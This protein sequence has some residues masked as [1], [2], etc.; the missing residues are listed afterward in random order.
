MICFDSEKKIL[1][2]L[3]RNTAYQMQIGPLGYLLHLYYG[4]RM[5]TPA[6]Y[7]YLSSDCGFSPNPY[8]LRMERTWSMDILPQEYSGSDSGDFRLSALHLNT[9]SGMHGADFRY[10]R[11]EISSGKYAL[12]GLPSASGN[13]SDV[14]TLTVTLA[15]AATGLTAQLFYGVY[16][17]ADIITRA[18]RLTNGGRENLFLEK[19]ASMC[20]DIPFGE[21][22]MMSFHGRH[23]MER[24]PERVPLTHDIRT[25]SSRRGMSSHQRNPFVILCARDATED[26]G[27]CYGMMPMYSGNHKTEIECDQMDSV[28]VVSGIHDEQFRWRLAPGETFDTPEILLGFSHEGLTGL[29]RMYHS[30]LRRH[31]CRAVSAPRPV[32]IN[33]WEAT[34]FN[35]DTEKILRIGR[36]ARELGADMLVLDDGWFGRRNDDNSGL[37]DWYVNESKLP[38]GLNVLIERL[39]ETGLKFGLWVEPEMVSEDSDLY[40]AHPDW[41][42]TVPG[43][44]PAMGRN[45]LVLDLSRKEVTG[46]MYETLSSLLKSHD[47]SYIKWDMNRCLADVYSHALPSERQGEVFHRYVLGLYSVLERLTRAFPHVLVEGCAGGGGRFD[48]GM[49]TYCPQIWCSDDTDAVE[50]LA[51]QHGTSFG[52][53]PCTM[54][55]HVSAVPNHQTGRCVPL[56]TRAVVAMAGTFGYELDLNRLSDD[57][58][59]QVREQIQRFH[60]Y[61]VLM[62]EGDYY[63]LAQS[64]ENQRFTAWQFVSPDRSESLVSL[65]V[66]HPRANPQPLHVR[67]KGLNPDADYKVVRREFFGSAVPADRL[68]ANSTGT[69]ERHY[70]GASLMYAGYT[71]P[72]MFG[73]YPSAQIYLKCVEKS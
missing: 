38:G 32:L 34:Y 27:E 44:R 49:L 26:S 39:K 8:E 25:V 4:R 46:W 16:E 71:F 61:D 30:F 72:G 60:E 45:Q 65:V 73:D 29:S 43:R 58:K 3:T 50:R 33:N 55:A 28:R 48:A 12:S 59:Q 62:R 1:T 47:I 18:V 31:V 14:E 22:D 6:D 36:Q 5:D 17:Q 54:G 7:L 20:L 52:Y 40:R 10:V 11:H 66:T 2:C 68:Y 15:D 51:I 42:L 37:G 24:Q 69:T 63:R 67:F 70:S 35:F 53:P 64:W 57:E 13:P 41:A 56:G 23:A 9:Q 21:W 19:A